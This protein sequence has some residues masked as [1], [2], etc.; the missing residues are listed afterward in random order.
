VHHPLQL[1]AFFFSIFP[2]FVLQNK[3]MV[4]A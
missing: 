4:P 2:S 1:P 3:L